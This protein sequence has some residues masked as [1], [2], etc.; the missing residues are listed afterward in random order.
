MTIKSA[1]RKYFL[2]HILISCE[3]ICDVLYLDITGVSG[4]LYKNK[5]L[6]TVF[7]SDL[8][9]HASGKRILI[10]IMRFFLKSPSIDIEY[11]SSLCG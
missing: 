4:K 2:S 8:L 3:T 6:L 1:S 10:Y 5:C 9:G 7:L 11:L